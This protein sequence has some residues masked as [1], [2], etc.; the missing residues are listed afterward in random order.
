MLTI[1]NLKKSHG[2]RLLFEEADMQVNYGERV[3]LAER[4]VLQPAGLPLTAPAVIGAASAI[5]SALA[6]CAQTWD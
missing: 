4:D 5:A 6:K 1:R 3:A 2:G